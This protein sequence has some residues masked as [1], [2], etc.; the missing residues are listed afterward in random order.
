VLS[1][2]ILLILSVRNVRSPR[3]LVRFLSVPCHRKALSHLRPIFRTVYHPLTLTQVL[4]HPCAIGCFTPFLSL[5]R[6]FVLPLLRF[7]S[8]SF[9]RFCFS[10]CDRPFPFPPLWS[11]VPNCFVFVIAPLPSFSPSSLR[12][13]LTLPTLRTCLHPTL[14]HF[15]F[16]TL[17]VVNLPFPVF[18]PSYCS[19][20]HPC[21]PR[22]PSQ[23]TVRLIPSLFL[24]PQSCTLPRPLFSF[25]P[26]T[27]FTAVP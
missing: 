26:P 9:A 20:P 17:S 5:P 16:L 24:Y 10:L 21:T 12:P 18:G 25:L 19:L 6:T 1:S 22:F 3:P 15:F 2:D 4:Y 23:P 8:S 14:S 11:W 13:S 7:C 27:I